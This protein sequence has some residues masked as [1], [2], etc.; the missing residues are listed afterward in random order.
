M[1]HEKLCAKCHVNPRVLHKSYCNPCRAAYMRDWRSVEKQRNESL[2]AE[3]QST[4]AIV[5]RLQEKQNHKGRRKHEHAA[6]RA[7]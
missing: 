7:A 2:K 1:F 4:K 3:L 5:A 6:K